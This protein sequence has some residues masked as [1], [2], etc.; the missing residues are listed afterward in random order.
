M[1]HSLVNL[2]KKRWEKMDHKHNCTAFKKCHLES[3]FLFSLFTWCAVVHADM[4]RSLWLT[5]LSP[6]RCQTSLCCLILIN[7]VWLR[8]WV[9]IILCK[10]NWTI[11]TITEFYMIVIYCMIIHIHIYQSHACMNDSAATVM[12]KAAPLGFQ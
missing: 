5:Y 9:I 6:N 3:C 4:K 8:L 1:D 12:H 11:W 2:V 7:L 10:Y